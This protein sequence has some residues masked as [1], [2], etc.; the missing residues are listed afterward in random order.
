M[1]NLLLYIYSDLACQLIEPTRSL[2]EPSCRRGRGDGKSWSRL[3]V[4]IRVRD[5]VGSCFPRGVGAGI[6]ATPLRGRASDVPCRTM[7]ARLRRSPISSPAFPLHPP[8]PAATFISR[9]HLSCLLYLPPL[10]SHDG[11]GRRVAVPCPGG[12][13]QHH[14]QEAHRDAAQELVLP[15]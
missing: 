7:A 5:P 10:P 14:R 2:N 1:R 13:R 9:N 15:R 11:A 8:L 12:G 3:V 6:E 4:E